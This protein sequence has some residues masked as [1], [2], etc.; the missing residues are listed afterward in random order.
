MKG[1]E[2]NAMRVVRS[3]CLRGRRFGLGL[4]LAISCGGSSFHLPAKDLC[5]DLLKFEYI[6]DKGKLRAYIPNV[7]LG[8]L[9]TIGLATFVLSETLL[10]STA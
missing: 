9:D 2:D 6:S 3:R 1:H 7:N 8:P 10:Q 5:T 4:G